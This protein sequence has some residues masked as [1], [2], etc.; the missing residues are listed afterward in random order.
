MT[1]WRNKLE[2]R[3]NERILPIHVLSQDAIIS[4][5]WPAS[6]TIIISPV[7]LY[8]LHEQ[9]FMEERLDMLKNILTL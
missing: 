3:K 4:M 8:A 9:F 6:C 5:A 7:L 1:R 2:K